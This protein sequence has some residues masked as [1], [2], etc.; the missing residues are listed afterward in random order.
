MKV[1]RRRD[2]TPDIDPRRWA[3]L[4]FTPARS[5]SFTVDLRNCPLGVPAF[6]HWRPD[7]TCLCGAPEFDGGTDNQ[8]AP[9][10]A[11]CDSYQ[12]ARAQ[13]FAARAADLAPKA[14]G[15]AAPSEP[16]PVTSSAELG[17]VL[18]AERATSGATGR[19]SEAPATGDNPRPK[20]APARP[21]LGAE[22]ALFGAWEES[23]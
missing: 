23:A 13:L 8:G 16:G 11:G 22:E 21:D 15:I 17:A 10:R 3:F 4:R 20:V 6:S 7:G 5:T 19:E 2:T 12:S 14:G 9:A 1:A 18:G